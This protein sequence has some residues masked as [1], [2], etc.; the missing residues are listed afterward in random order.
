VRVGV[1]Q[2]VGKRED[3]GL[4]AQP[5]LGRRQIVEDGRIGRRLWHG[6]CPPSR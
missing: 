5:V 1:K 6:F 4:K 2:D 3:V